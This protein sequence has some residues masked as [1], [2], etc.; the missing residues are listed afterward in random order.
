[1]T[2]PFRYIKQELKEIEGDPLEDVM[3]IVLFAILCCGLGIIA[4]AIKGII[5]LIQ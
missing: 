1:M 4:L 3:K 2:N 5:Y